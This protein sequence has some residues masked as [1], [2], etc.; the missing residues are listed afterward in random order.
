MNHDGTTFPQGNNGSLV[1]LV[2]EAGLAVDLGLEV[3]PV[4]VGLL[5][6]RHLDVGQ[7][8][9]GAVDLH[10]VGHLVLFL[11]KPVDDGREHFGVLL[12]I[13]GCGHAEVASTEHGG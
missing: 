7:R 6:H 3:E 5:R 2:F 10:P 11:R 4:V 12:H 1:G 13:A 8:W 9:I